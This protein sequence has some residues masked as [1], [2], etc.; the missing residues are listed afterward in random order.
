MA[1]EGIEYKGKDLR[2]LCERL[3]A[4]IPEQMIQRVVDKSKGQ[5]AVLI[6]ALLCTTG[7][8]DEI[9]GEAVDP[10]GVCGDAPRK[11]R[12]RVARALGS[13]KVLREADGVGQWTV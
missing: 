5:L 2:S 1:L 11:V 9:S 13:L 6:A 3:F 10:C 8:V 7:S 12:I 4:P